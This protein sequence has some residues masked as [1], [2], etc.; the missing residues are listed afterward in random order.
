LSEAKAFLA[1]NFMAEIKITSSLKKG[2]NISIVFP[3]LH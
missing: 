3:D 2:T 1:D